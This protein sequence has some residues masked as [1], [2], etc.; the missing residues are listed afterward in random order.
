MWQRIVFEFASAIMTGCYTRQGMLP[1]G[2]EI[3][4]CKCG[5]DNVSNDR[6]NNNNDVS[7][8]ASWEKRVYKLAIIQGMTKAF[9]SALDL[10][11]Y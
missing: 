5:I 6:D 10:P 1:G 3:V 7:A 8:L 11:M 4:H 9:K 2:L